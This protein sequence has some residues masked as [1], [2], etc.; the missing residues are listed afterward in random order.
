M[1]L[2]EEYIDLCVGRRS[3]ERIQ[4]TMRCRLMISYLR[5][6]CCES[7]GEE[8]EVY[9]GKSNGEGETVADGVLEWFEALPTQDLPTEPQNFDGAF[10]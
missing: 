8:D 6:V 3:G 9:D 1:D 2:W 5:N 10:A 7:V 4:G